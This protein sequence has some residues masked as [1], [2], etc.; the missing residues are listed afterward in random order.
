MKS[1]RRTRQNREVADC[2]AARAGPAGVLVEH[3]SPVAC[4]AWSPDGQW[5]AAATQD[6]TV[7]IT[8][9]ATGKEVRSFLAG[10]AISG[11]AFSPDGKRLVLS[12]AGDPTSIW[13]IDAGKQQVNAGGG[14]GGGGEAETKDPSP[15][16][17]WRSRR[18]A[19]RSCASPW[20]RCCGRGRRVAAE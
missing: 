20:V 1:R 13:D 2:G 10:A 4:L 14:G 15:P 12:R 16:R 6:D 5:V 18:T 19:N 3:K 7:H 8:E 11:L 17:T 9:L